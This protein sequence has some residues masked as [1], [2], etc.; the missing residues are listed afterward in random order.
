MSAELAVMLFSM[1]IPLAL[2]LAPLLITF[3]A[4]EIVNFFVKRAFWIIGTYSLMLNGAIAGSLALNS[5]LPVLE[6]VNRFTWLVAVM[7]WLM[8]LYLV[9]STIFIM[10]SMI[11]EKKLNIRMGGDYDEN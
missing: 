10:L 2:Y 11:S 6:E 3:S 1:S 7:G 4:N 5:S 8:I 9:L